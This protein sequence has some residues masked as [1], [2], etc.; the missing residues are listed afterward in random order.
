MTSRI[1]LIGECMIE[2]SGKAFS[3]LVQSW[4]GDTYNTAVYLRRLLPA[5][6]Q[7][8]YI[9]GMGED[10]LSQ[11][12]LMQW[13]QQGLNLDE[14]RL[15]AGRSPGIYQIS[16]D[17]EG[18]RSF[19]YW[20]NDAAAK[21]V[22]DGVKAQTLASR[23]MHY[24]YLYLSGISLA[25][26][27]PEGRQT[28]LQAL[29]QY[30]EN[31]GTLVFDNNYRPKLWKSKTE[32]QAL[33]QQV[34]SMAHIALLTLDDEN[35]LWGSQQPDDVFSMWSCH[36]VVIKRGG[37]DC[38]LRVNGDS[39]SVAAQRVDSVVDTT[40]AGDSFSAGYLYGRIMGETP[41]VS[42]LYGH[43]L[44]GRVIQYAGAMIDENHMPDLVH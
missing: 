5:E 18:E 40:A 27:T 21:F 41:V 26:L 34:L 13:Q 4:G 17:A 1:A 3:H 20:R 29:S 28:L 14:V 23:L 32:C 16:T 7:V 6:H 9:T 33:Y 38:L 22:F 15:I 10:E 43:Q 30:V 31:G 8:S 36:E 25:I 11:H 35:A 39:F 12:M 37:Q 24:D 2:L 19:H 42:A 44:A